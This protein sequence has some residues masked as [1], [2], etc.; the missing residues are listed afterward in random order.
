MTGINLLS[1][2]IRRRRLRA[3]IR[4][5]D[6]VLIISLD[7]KQMF[8]CLTRLT[9][10]VTFKAAGAH[11]V[12]LIH[13]LLRFSNKKIYLTSDRVT[14]RVS[15]YKFG[16]QGTYSAWCAGALLMAP[17]LLAAQVAINICYDESGNLEDER[18]R[19]A[20]TWIRTA[21]EIIRSD[22]RA[23]RCYAMRDIDGMYQKKERAEDEKP[24]FLQDF[25]TSIYKQFPH[26]EKRKS[27]MGCVD[28][29]DLELVFRQADTTSRLPT[30]INM[31]TEH[32]EIM[33]EV[34]KTF[35]AINKCEAVVI[36]FEDSADAAAAC[37]ETAQKVQQSLKIFG[38][39][40]KLVKSVKLFGFPVAC[41][42]GRS[43]TALCR[44]LIG[45][46]LPI[47]RESFRILGNKPKHAE[48][49]LI[50][51]WATISKVRHLLVVLKR[52]DE[53]LFDEMTC[54]IGKKLM[55]FY[56]VSDAL[57]E[58][59]KS[60]FLEVEGKTVSAADIFFA[61][62]LGNK[63]W[64]EKVGRTFR[65]AVTSELAILGDKKCDFLLEAAGWGLN[66]DEEE[67]RRNLL[68]DESM[69]VAFPSK[70]SYDLLR[71]RSVLKIGGASIVLEG[72]NDDAPTYDYTTD[73]AIHR[74]RNN[75]A[76]LRTF[77]GKYF[78]ASLRPPDVELLKIRDAGNV[79]YAANAAELVRRHGQLLKGRTTWIFSLPEAAI[80]GSS[81]ITHELYSAVA[82]AT[83]KKQSPAASG[84]RVQISSSSIVWNQRRWA[85]IV[86]AT[87]SSAAHQY[88]N[89]LAWE[90]GDPIANDLSEEIHDI[91]EDTYILGDE[92]AQ[93][94]ERIGTKKR[95]EEIVEKFTN[96]LIRE[97]FRDAAEPPLPGDPMEIEDL[98]A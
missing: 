78:A 45:Y 8:N 5:E 14:L 16:V 77:D 89:P 32:F 9:A 17:W 13:N 28:D 76:Y 12:F 53:P 74:G 58:E 68:H 67:T 57:Q 22:F 27:A 40:I 66:P 20:R 11:P 51:G 80:N 72:E 79:T 69:R 4:Q 96:L 62:F 15:D 87:T 35:I 86:P 60:G 43:Y 2:E 56:G 3:S 61:G 59:F 19:V 42:V 55:N 31:V 71:A 98:M 36:S 54:E 63:N 33:A 84:P 44:R 46:A 38:K 21:Q 70:V 41:Q 82:S 26:A 64:K 18:I 97:G 75:S 23:A 93:E 88:I 37:N 39:A 50:P 30:V 6:F 85:R 24:D 10:H 95:K 65:K 48:F 47:V 83:Q 81:A 73:D 90:S 34:T 49:K 25:V 52:Y 29:T 94:D 7:L 92:E 91:F 1:T